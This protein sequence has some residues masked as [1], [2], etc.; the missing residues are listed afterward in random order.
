MAE[1]VALG[2]MTKA[3]R[4]YK[5]KVPGNLGAKKDDHGVLPMEHLEIKKLPDPIHFVKKYKSEF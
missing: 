5:P 4:R 3:K 2:L 1:R